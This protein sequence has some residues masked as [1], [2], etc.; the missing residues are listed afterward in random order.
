[1][2]ATTGKI[3]RA[4]L[5]RDVPEMLRCFGY[6]SRRRQRWV[7]Y[8]LELRVVASAPTWESLLEKLTLAVSIRLAQFRGNP[9]LH[10][11]RL[12]PLRMRLLYAGVAM[13]H[14]VRPRG[15]WGIAD[16]SRELLIDES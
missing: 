10:R 3:W 2:T 12:A 4:K 11:R 13:L 5:T 9:S 15:R 14:F 16:L 8:C 7:G 6:W 1:M